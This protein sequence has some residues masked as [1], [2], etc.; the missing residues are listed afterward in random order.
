MHCSQFAK[1]GG[2]NGLKK[3]TKRKSS[4]SWL[5]PLVFHGRVR[6]GA[7]KTLVPSPYL[8]RLLEGGEI[9]FFEIFQS[10]RTLTRKNM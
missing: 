4:S 9:A 8:D 1:V 10:L 5:V 3:P 7:I 2:R 6:E